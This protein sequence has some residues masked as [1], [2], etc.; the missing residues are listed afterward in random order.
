[1]ERIQNGLRKLSFE[2]PASICN[3]HAFQA[4]MLEDSVD[5][6]KQIW[7]QTVNYQAYPDSQILLNNHSWV[8]E[9]SQTEPGTQLGY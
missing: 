7:D 3:N 4:L 9:L 2:Q 8:K 5:K 1:M 6:Q